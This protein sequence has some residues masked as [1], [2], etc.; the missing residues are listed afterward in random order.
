MSK[1]EILQVIRGTD[2]IKDA[3]NEGEAHAL[4]T[5]KYRLR[6]NKKLTMDSEVVVWAKD[7]LDA[8]TRAKHEI[9]KEN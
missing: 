7:E 9:A 3:V 2:D 6:I 1:I 8:Y 5:I 4:F